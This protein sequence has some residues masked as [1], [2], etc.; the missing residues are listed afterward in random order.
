MPENGFIFTDEDVKKLLNKLENKYHLSTK[1][2]LELWY[3]AEISTYDA[4][5][6]HYVPDKD[7][8]DWIFCTELLST[9]IEGP[10][11]KCEYRYIAGE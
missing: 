4:S 11:G 8:H 1:K 2:F 5:A 10:D 3:N 7:A 6:E 9:L